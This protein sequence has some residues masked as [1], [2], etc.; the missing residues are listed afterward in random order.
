MSAYL[1][2]N[3]RINDR[4]AYDPYLV[5]VASI[6]EAHGAEILAADF[7]SEALEGDA[8]HVTVVLRFPSKEAAKGWYDSPEYQEIIGLRL[9]NCDGLA[10]LAN[11]SGG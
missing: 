8:G 3:Y 10:V 11:G 9:E 4:E 2:F 1:V 7:A 6:L 5:A